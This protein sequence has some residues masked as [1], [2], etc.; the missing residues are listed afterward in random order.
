MTDL[1]VIE[2]FY[3]QPWPDSTRLEMLEWLSR[4]GFSRFLFAPK[5]ETYLRSDWRDALTDE[6]VV[7]LRL[8]QQRAS[9]CEM[10]LYVGLSPYEA[11]EQY[12]TAT[13]RLLFR[14]LDE[15]GAVGITSLA[16][17]F[18]DMS[19]RVDA[20]AARQLE[21]VSDIRARFPE[22]SLAVC[23]T[24]YSDDP[25]LDR[26][27]GQRPVTYLEDFA[28]GLEADIEVFWTGPAVCSPQIEPEDLATVAGLFGDRLALWDNYPV[29]DSA[30]RSTHLYIQPIDR[31][32]L[33]LESFLSSH[34]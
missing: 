31:D 26:V 27:F 4:C 7:R 2:G 30:L 33:A 22:W 29:N 6:Q 24:Y 25:V 23:P 32:G 21:I 14:K 11:Y 17:L 5:N 19:G 34:W 28:A 16:V 15:I 3:G 10:R 18:D 1:G 12:D 20:L 8:M 9:A 13:R